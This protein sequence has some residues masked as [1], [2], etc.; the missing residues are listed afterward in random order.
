VTSGRAGRIERE[1]T[2]LRDSTADPSARPDSAQGSNRRRREQELAHYRHCENV[3][4]LPAIHH[5]WSEHY[6]LP[7]LVACGFENTDELFL[8]YLVGACQEEP[9]R[10]CA[11]ASLGAGNCDLE[12]RLASLARARGVEN[13]RFHCLELNPDMIERGR[14]LA[15]QAELADRFTFEVTDLEAWQPDG[16]LSACLANHSLHHLVGLERLFA[17][18]RG[19]L[20]ERGVFL[21]NDMIGRNGHLRW[22]E[23]LL[24]VE[25]IWRRLPARYKYNHQLRRL[26]LDFEDWD[27]SAEGNEGIRAQDVLPLL[28]EHF[29][30]DTFVAFGNVIDVFVDRSFGHNFDPNT[31]E[32]VAWIERIAQLDDALLD[33]GAVKPTH[34]IAALRA[35]P[36]GRLHCYRHWTPDFCVRRSDVEAGGPAGFGG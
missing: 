18:I 21:I 22:P 8:S 36:T 35:C 12:V 31:P 28:I 14:R 29:H 6:V 7:K 3:H 19:A 1:A 10:V 23:A 11:V 25:R 27:C 15:H 32:D 16:A 24:F 2:T 20:G 4:D 26:E 30:F 9:E 5:H 13:L 17:G 34:A 33:A